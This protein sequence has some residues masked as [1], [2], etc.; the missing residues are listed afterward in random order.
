MKI[1]ILTQPLHSNYGGLLQNYALQQ[2]LIW[3]G[4]EVETIDWEGGMSLREKLYRAKMKMMH[5]LLLSKYPALRYRP[6]V[7]EQ[8]VIQ[9]NTKRFINTYINHTDAVHSRSGFVKQAE[10]GAYDAFELCT[11]PAR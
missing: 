10:R 5:M 3:A 8:N 1:G 7:K 4:Y 6:N 9:R 11:K 2:T